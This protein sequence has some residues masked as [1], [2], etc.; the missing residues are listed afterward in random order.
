MNKGNEENQIYREKC[1]DFFLP[2]IDFISVAFS[3]FS[4]LLFDLQG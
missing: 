4:L 1:T 3:D 2:N